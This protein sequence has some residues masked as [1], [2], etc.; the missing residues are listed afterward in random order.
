[1]FAILVVSGNAGWAQTYDFDTFL[2]TVKQHNKDLRLASQEKKMADLQQKEALSGAL[3]SVGLEAGYTRNLSDYYM[4]FDMSALDPS[5]SGVV[6]APIKRN[7]ELSSSIGLQQTLYS[8]EVKNA[9]KASRQYSQLTDFAY[10]ATEQSV[11]S[12]AKKLFFQCLFLEKVKD[13]TIAAEQNAQENFDIMQLKYDNGQVSEFELLQAETRWRSAIPDVQQAERNCKLAMNNLK[14]MAGI[15]INQDITLTGSLDHTPEMPERIA[16]EHVFGARPDFQA[17]SWQKELL[18]T[19]LDAAKGAYQPKVT[20]TLAYSY[21]SQSDKMELAEENNLWFVGVNISMPIYTGGYIKSQI[22]KA[23]VE[24]KKTN[25]EIEKNKETIS[26]D[27]VNAYLR[28]EE[29][30]LRIESAKS[31]LE[32]AEKAFRIAEATTRDGLTTQLQLK[33]ARLAFDQAK[34]HYYAAI[35]DYLA[36]YFDWEY[37]LGK[38]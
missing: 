22:E 32:T 8:S 18:K 21:S 5:A 28:L 9:I 38:V 12:N 23:S 27:V 19:N 11:V 15:D 7:N 1:M 14:N 37:A 17:L 29:A 20:G 4:Y 13:I 10:E 2:G 25:I 26:T 31:T 36:A 34:I 3:P 35:F 16:M 33:D 30:D 6:K 24:L